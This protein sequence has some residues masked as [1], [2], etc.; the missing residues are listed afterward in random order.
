VAL[1]VGTGVVAAIADRLEYRRV[2]MEDLRP[3]YWALVAVNAVLYGALA[4]ILAGFI[5]AGQVP[6]AIYAA[7]AGVLM[8]AAALLLMWAQGPVGDVAWGAGRA[9]GFLLAGAYLVISGVQ[10]D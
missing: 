8:A 3:H 2:P 10:R 6:R 9:V 7:A 4:V 1:A 5:P